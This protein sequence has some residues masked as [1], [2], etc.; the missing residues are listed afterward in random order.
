MGHR[1]TAHVSL[2]SLAVEV[3]PIDLLHPDPAT[4][5]LIGKEEPAFSPGPQA[6]GMGPSPTNPVILAIVV[7]LRDVEQRRARGKVLTHPTSK[8]PAP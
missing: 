7:A 4:H 2:P 5:R 6:P 8:R 1:M 3:V